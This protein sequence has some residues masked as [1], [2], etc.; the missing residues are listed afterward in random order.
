MDGNVWRTSRQSALK[1]FAR[2]DTYVRERDCHRLLFDNNVERLVGFQVPELD[3]GNAHVDSPPDY[4][5][6]DEGRLIPL[7]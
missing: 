5:P 6:S 2:R 7:E 1:V 3:V 4:S